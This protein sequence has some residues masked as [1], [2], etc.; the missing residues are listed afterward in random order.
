VIFKDTS[1]LYVLSNTYLLRAA[2]N[3][4]KSDGRL[5]KK[6]VFAAVVYFLIS[7][8]ASRSVKMLERRMAIAR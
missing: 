4:A 7:Y 8:A 2:S 1:Q 3:V 6:I 5:V